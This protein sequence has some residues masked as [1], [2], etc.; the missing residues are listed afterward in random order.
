LIVP[1]DSGLGILENLTKHPVNVEEYASGSYMSEIRLPAGLDVEDFNDLRRQRYTSVV[2]LDIATRLTKL[3]EVVPTRT[4]VRYARS[5]TADDIRNSNVILLGSKH[6]DPWVSLFEKSLNFKL[7]YTPYTDQ[8]YVLN[9]HPLGAEEK[10][11]R[12]TADARPGPTYG[13]IAYLPEPG[14]AGHA[15]V[16]EGLNMAA[17]QAAAD[18]LFNPGAIEPVLK[19]AK[20]PDGSLEQFECLIETTSIG[21]TAPGAQIIATRIH[22]R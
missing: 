13:V 21:A 18:I 6:T 16:I 5:I 15:L 2:D 9:E 14:G 3:L 12:N 8:S 10:V 1:A 11:Y 17:T 22:S 20:L 19:Q 4:Q 7:E